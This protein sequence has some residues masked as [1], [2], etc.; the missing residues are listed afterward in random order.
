MPDRSK[1]SGTELAREIQLT[2]WS[3]A[4][5]P[6]NRSSGV[7]IPR[8]ICT[9]FRRYLYST[10]CSWIIIMII[11]KS[12]NIVGSSDGAVVRALVSRVLFRPGVICGL[13]LLLVLVLVPSVFLRVSGFPPSTKTPNSY[14]TCF[15]STAFA[16]Q[17]TFQPASVASEIRERLDLFNTLMAL[18]TCSALICNDSLQF[19]MEIR[20]ISRL[21]PVSEEGTELGRFTMLFSQRT[22]KEMYKKL[23]C[24]CTAIV[25][26]T[27]GPL[28]GDRQCVLHNKN[29]EKFRQSRS[30]RKKSSLTS[31]CIVK[32]KISGGI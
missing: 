17:C 15:R 7:Q 23:Q 16:T 22:G 8:D 28:F 21:P 25:F 4:G 10:K 26:L 29:H 14:S 18:K 30:Q 5:N 12:R 20:K 2:D 13:S 1:R 3:T 24:T 6:S 32:G 31:R 27:N 19:Q 11:S 9:R